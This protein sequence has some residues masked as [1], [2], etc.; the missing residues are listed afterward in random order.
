[1]I[2]ILK[3]ISIWKTN[4][5]TCRTHLQGGIRGKIHKRIRKSGKVN[6]ITGVFCCSQGISICW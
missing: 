1:M 3:R 2:Y 4:Q 5:W 6:L